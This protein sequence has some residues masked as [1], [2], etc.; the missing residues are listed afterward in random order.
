[1]PQG[2]HVETGHWRLDERGLV[3]SIEG[4]SAAVIWHESGYPDDLALVFEAQ[5]MPGH[6]SDAN[7]FFRAAGSI[8]GESPNDAWIVGTA[9][10][11]VHD[12]GLER[13]PNGSTWR[14]PGAPLKR[15]QSV[16][17]AAGYHQGR[18]F[19]WK[20]GKLLLEETTPPEKETTPHHRLGLGTWDSAVRFSRLS[21]YDLS[22]AHHGPCT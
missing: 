3:G 20:D 2:W 16:R 4:D 14:V 21:V 6:D 15:E 19:L 5:A 18:V 8:Y 7:G 9:G 17:V 10:W 11:Y 13:H 22:G 12:D 1:L